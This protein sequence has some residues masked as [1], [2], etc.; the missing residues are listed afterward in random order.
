MQSP[1]GNGAVKRLPKEVEGYP[2]APV[3]STPSWG[4]QTGC[5]LGQGLG[6]GESSRSQALARGNAAPAG[7]PRP[8]FPGGPRE[9]TV[10]RAR[11]AGDRAAELVSEGAES[12]SPPERCRGR[13]ERAFERGG[14]TRAGYLWS[15]I[16]GWF[17]A[18]K[19]V[20]YW[21]AA[22]SYGLCCCLSPPGT[23]SPAKGNRCFFVLFLTFIELCPRGGCVPAHGSLAQEQEVTGANPSPVLACWSLVLGRAASPSSSSSLQPAAP[24]QSNP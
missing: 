13:A 24:S 22:S 19:D 18:I 1:D 6:S 3:G 11:C 4:T 12:W 8:K 10:Q 14:D 7:S 5:V 21:R 15:H 16:A 9:G 23:A 17:F 20:T 2:K